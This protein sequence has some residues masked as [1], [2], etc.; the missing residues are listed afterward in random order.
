MNILVTGGAGFIGSNFLALFAPRYPE[1]LFVNVDKL[2]YAA[3]LFS[4]REIA[5]LP[6]YRFEQ[7][8][9]ADQAAVAELFHRYEP[10]LIVHFAA[11]SHVDRSIHG[12]ADFIRTNILG[13]FHLLEACRVRWGEGRD[14][15][16]HHVS[17]DEVYGSLTTGA[18]TEDSPYNPSS[19]YSASKAASDHLVRAYYKTFGLPVKIT[20]CS[21]NYGPRQFP[22]KLIPFMLLRALEGKPLPLYGDGRQV[23]DWL[24]VEDHCQAIWTVIERGRLGETYNIGGESEKTNLEVVRTICRLLAEETG[25]AEEEFTRL[26]TFVPDRPGHDVRYAM[27]SSKIRR[28]LGWVPRESFLTGLRKTIRWYLHNPLWVERVKTGEYRRWVQTNYDDR[29]QAPACAGPVRRG[30]A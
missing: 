4:V 29:D 25:R 11:E 22:E 1:H 12:P 9:I 19:P 5:H 18:F 8:D 17:T 13:T 26:I 24:Y 2:T 7:V 23:R 20:N 10:N 6:N 28:E 30:E 21:N 14:V 27:D 16:F 3:N 15:L